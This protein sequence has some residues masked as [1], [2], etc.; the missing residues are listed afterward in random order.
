MDPIRDYKQISFLAVDNRTRFL[1]KLQHIR[2]TEEQS[3][4]DAQCK[5]LKEIVENVDYWHEPN[6]KLN[7]SV[8][9]VQQTVQVHNSAR[10]VT[11]QPIGKGI[12]ARVLIRRGTVFPMTGRL[13]D[14]DG[15]KA[16][17][18]EY[19]QSRRLYDFDIAT[20][21][22]LIFQWGLDGTNNALCLMNDPTGPQRLNN[23]IDLWKASLQRQEKE[24]N[25]LA[26]YQQTILHGNPDKEG[27]AIPT[28]ELAHMIT[29]QEPGILGHGQIQNIVTG[30][31]NFSS[32]FIFQPIGA[33]VRIKP[34]YYQPS[35]S[36]E[37]IYRVNHVVN[38]EFLLLQFFSE[39]NKTFEITEVGVQPGEFIK[40]EAYKKTHVKVTKPD[41]RAVTGRDVY[42]PL[43]T[44]ATLDA[45][46]VITQVKIP[47]NM[48]FF[49]AV[50]T[51]DIQPNE[52][53]LITYGEAY[54]MQQYEIE[55][56]DQ[57]E[58]NGTPYVTAYPAFDSLERAEPSPEKC[59][60]QSTENSCIE[61]KPVV[62]VALHK[63]AEKKTLIFMLDPSI[64]KE[65]FKKVSLHEWQEYAN[66]HLNNL[67][68]SY[69]LPQYNLSKQT[70]FDVT[71]NDTQILEHDVRTVK[72][73]GNKVDLHEIE[74]KFKSEVLQA[75]EECLTQM[76]ETGV[77]LEGAP[78]EGQ[79]AK[80]QKSKTRFSYRALPSGQ[81][82]WAMWHTDLSKALQQ[83]HVDS[84]QSGASLHQDVQLRVAPSM[85]H[86]AECLQ[87]VQSR[88]TE[89]NNANFC[90]PQMMQKSD[91]DIETPPSQ[92]DLQQFIKQ[93]FL[94][95]KA[96]FDHQAIMVPL[97]QNVVRAAEGDSDNL[98]ARVQNF[99]DFT[100]YPITQYSLVGA[101]R[102]LQALCHL[103]SFIGGQRHHIFASFAANNNLAK[104]HT[105]LK[106]FCIEFYAN[107]AEMRNTFFYH[108]IVQIVLA[109][110]PFCRNY[111]LQD[112]SADN[113]DATTADFSLL[114]QKIE[115]VYNFVTEL[116]GLF[117]ALFRSVKGDTQ[118]I[119][120]IKDAKEREDEEDEQQA[121]KTDVLER[122]RAYDLTDAD[123]MHILKYNFN[124]LSIVEGELN[125]SMDALSKGNLMR[126]DISMET[127][128]KYTDWILQVVRKLAM[129]V[130]T[131]AMIFGDLQ[132]SQ[133]ARHPNSL[134][135]AKALKRV[136][137]KHL[138][139]SI[140]PDIVYSPATPYIC[141]NSLLRDIEYV[142]WEL[143]NRSNDVVGYVMGLEAQSSPQNQPTAAAHLATHDTNSTTS[144][145]PF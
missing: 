24:G 34:Y 83:L 110:I 57:L 61:M 40:G 66:L 65:S 56:D 12:V 111:E 53:L 58:V 73:D 30:L 14:V 85:Q 63:T 116:L 26:M 107:K 114:L 19:Q 16:C 82:H 136:V 45:E 62:A 4:T 118:S 102:E 120:R 129:C 84:V 99:I 7:Q 88:M 79:P 105:I 67:W 35:D 106:D 93:L 5:H 3:W 68:T 101:N 144:N 139:C 71:Q 133:A 117:A 23:Q 9:Q 123:G 142:L 29:T 128:E 104:V 33:N 122:F 112:N 1:R 28:D 70:T 94:C 36:K 46:D 132:S 64:A 69:V 2:A 95:L 98:P 39:A 103:L 52:P 126:V 55:H 60:Q 91:I 97:Q 127:C 77:L 41:W 78:G 124:R 145:Q 37:K 22:D 80:K 17:G 27:C 89:P 72:I 119:M 15:L 18:E 90:G 109:E 48:P 76:G 10:E 125:I 86:L 138:P 135:I 59:L 54:W 81:V 38:K 143:S 21:P 100:V 32:K 51:K 87:G 141:L 115:T 43:K 25:K 108:A 131:P 8:Q 130:A 74:T 44:G 42:L 121:R 49:F 13:T 50:A 11:T 20:D 96:E 140:T 75:V 113:P 134:Q 137:D 31:K 6:L 92:E 47:K